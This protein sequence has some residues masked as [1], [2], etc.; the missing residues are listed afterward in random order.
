MYTCAFIYLIVVKQNVACGQFEYFR[1]R[2]R[3]WGND[4]ELPYTFRDD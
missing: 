3:N 4:K 1:D 2:V